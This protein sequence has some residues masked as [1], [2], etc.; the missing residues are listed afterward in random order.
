MIKKR[1]FKS[2]IAL[3][4]FINSVYSLYCSSSLPCR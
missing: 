4:L 3:C 1:V 2:K